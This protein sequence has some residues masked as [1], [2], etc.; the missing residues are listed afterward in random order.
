MRARRYPST[1]DVAHRVVRNS[2]PTRLCPNVSISWSS[3][4][5]AASV[6]TYC[7]ESGHLLD[8]L[9]EMKE[10]DRAGP[11]APVPGED[12]AGRKRMERERGKA[13]ERRHRFCAHSSDGSSRG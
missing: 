12:E 4:S 6:L 2:G 8:V 9:R 10:I 13:E 3:R 1:F 11:P 5:H 7:A